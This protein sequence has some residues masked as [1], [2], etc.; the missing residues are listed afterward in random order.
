V[1]YRARDGVSC[2]RGTLWRLEGNGG[3]TD[4]SL[5]TSHMTAS[6]TT[7]GLPLQQTSRRILRAPT[8][9][10]DD[11]VCVSRRV[12]RR[13]VGLH[14]SHAR[15]VGRKPIWQTTMPPP[16]HPARTPNVTLSCELDLTNGPFGNDPFS[17]PLYSGTLNAQRPAKDSTPRLSSLSNFPGNPSYHNVYLYRVLYLQ[18]I[19]TG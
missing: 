10:E 3:L 17:T 18:I 4:S 8:L 11:H 7:C 1:I 5:G 13:S 14:S 15:H 19:C 16:R 6:L 9:I 12:W 2:W